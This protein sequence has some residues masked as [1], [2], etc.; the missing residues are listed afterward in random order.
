MVTI[1]FSFP[2][3]RFYANPWGHNVNEGFLEWPPSPWRILRALIATWHL[4]CK[5]DIP[6]ELVREVISELAKTL[7]VYYLPTAS[8]GHTRH[9][10]PSI[11][12]KTEKPTKIF[13]TFINVS[14]V[15]KISW[16]IDINS[17]QFS[18]LDI[19]CKRLGYLGRAE[20]VVEARAYNCPEKYEPNAFPLPENQPVPSGKELI[21][22]LLP[23][24]SDEYRRWREANVDYESFKLEDGGKKKPKRVKTKQK[25]NL[26][27]DI[28]SALHSDTEDLRVQGW[29]IPPGSKYVDYVRPQNCFE[30]K[31]KLSARLYETKPTVARFKIASAVLPRITEAISVAERIHIDLL[32]KFKNTKAPEVLSGRGADGSPLKG[33]RHLYI[34][35]EPCGR[36]DLITHITLFARDG[37]GEVE[38]KAIEKL[39]NVWGKG[40]HDIQL[41]LID[42]GNER[43]FN[44]CELFGESEVW[45]SLTPFVPTCHP[46]YYRDGRPKLDKEGWHIGSPEHD[47]RR[48]IIE[49]SLPAP[50]KIERLKSVTIGGRNIHWLQFRTF[51]VHGNG[52]SSGQPPVGFKIT[53]PEKVRGPIAFGYGAHFGLGLFRPASK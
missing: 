6:E 46:K 1:E 50:T 8:S 41:V 2:A 47:L 33:H 15:L 16:N 38:R 32:S 53:F 44:D 49:S 42:F 30:I 39:K 31:P 25:A 3:G 23:M 10:M 26:P 45:Q 52:V 11:E 20:S 7:P 48:L 22:L 4:K 40:G 5:N 36:L 18:A 14:D 24:G 27:D 17:R 9:Y 13:D 29:Q 19:L 37:F 21:R 12:G 43:S 28:F 35:C 51:R 34:F